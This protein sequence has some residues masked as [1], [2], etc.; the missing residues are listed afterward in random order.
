[1]PEH[2]PDLKDIGYYYALAQVGLEMVTPLLIGVGLDYYFGTKP[3]ITVTGTVLGFV[4]GF[5]HLVMMINRH[6]AE[7]R[8]RD[9]DGGNQ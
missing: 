2:P 9:R 1:M 3:W 6:E 8:P 7:K 5:V 4:G